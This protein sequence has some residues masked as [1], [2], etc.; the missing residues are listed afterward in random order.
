MNPLW[1]IALAAGAVALVVRAFRDKDDQRGS[2]K[3][4]PLTLRTPDATR[5]RM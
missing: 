3:E 4:P 1:A 2:A 5:R